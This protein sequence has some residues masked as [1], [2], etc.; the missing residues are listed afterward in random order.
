MN[1]FKPVA[2]AVALFA[3]LGAGNANAD[4]YFWAVN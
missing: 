3:A 4:S 2:A 1:S